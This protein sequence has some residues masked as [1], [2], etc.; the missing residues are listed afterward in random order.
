MPLATTYVQFLRRNGLVFLK[1]PN[2][3]T[4]LNRNSS[5]HFENFCV[6]VHPLRTFCREIM[7]HRG[8]KIHWLKD[9]TSGYNVR[10]VYLT[11]WVSFPKHKAKDRTC[12]N[13]NNGSHS[14]IFCVIIV[15]VLWTFLGEL[16]HCKGSK[17]Y[18]HKDNSSGYN[19]CTV[20]P[21]KW[22]SFPKKSERSNM[23]KS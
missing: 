10:T 19:V 13:R 6:I 16:M 21:T 18:W 9:N 7:H 12:L 11:R 17:I 23:S 8:Y 1:K 4:C 14:Q 3:R 15:C 2:D 5:G 20:Y 22:L